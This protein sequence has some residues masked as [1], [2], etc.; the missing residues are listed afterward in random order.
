MRT[1]AAAEGG[2]PL[3]TGVGSPIHTPTLGGADCHTFVLSHLRSPARPFVSPP[4]SQPSP[5]IQIIIEPLVCGE[6]DGAGFASRREARSCWTLP[7]VE[8]FMRMTSGWVSH[9]GTPME[10]PCVRFKYFKLR[11]ILIHKQLSSKLRLMIR[12]FQCSSKNLQ[13]RRAQFV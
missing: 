2:N 1:R 13:S 12:Q 6:T 9:E 5:L 3:Q 10:N 7:A 11:V 8:V 4:W